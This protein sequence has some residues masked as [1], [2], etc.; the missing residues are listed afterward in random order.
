MT[1]EDIKALAKFIHIYYVRETMID[2]KGYEEPC[3]RCIELATA[4]YNAGYR[5]PVV[6]INKGKKLP[7]QCPVCGKFGSNNCI[8]GDNR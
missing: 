8:C 6:K 7:K 1:K 3:D 2:P 4:L 5:L